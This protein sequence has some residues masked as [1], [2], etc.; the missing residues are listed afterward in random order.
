LEIHRS[1]ARNAWIVGLLAVVAGVAAFW[2]WGLSNT[3]TSGHSDKAYMPNVETLA[4][5]SA[6]VVKGTV[7]DEGTAGNL[8]RDADDPRKESSTVVPGT[9]Y[10][11]VVEQAIKGD[12]PAG[13]QIKVAVSGGKYKGKSEPLAA[14]VVAKKAYYFF[15]LP[16]SMG[17]PYYFG[18][19]EPFVFESA[20]GVIRPVTNDAEAR[21]TFTDAG[22]TEEQWLGKAQR[23]PR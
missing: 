17:A 18:A 1:S 12:I 15:L 14:D 16:S 9:D 23:A 5:S 2:V 4:E 20:E 11:V 22:L 6:I 10:T 21:K 13:T 7:L 19:G 3:G 8:R